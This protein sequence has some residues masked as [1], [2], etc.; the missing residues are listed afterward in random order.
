M[1]G[2]WTLPA[3]L[4]SDWR[5][6]APPLVVWLTSTPSLEIVKISPSMPWSKAKTVRALA[7]SIVRALARL[8]ASFLHPR[9]TE[10][11]QLMHGTTELNTGVPFAL[12]LDSR[13]A[14]T[15]CRIHG[16]VLL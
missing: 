5:W 13:P 1:T 14:S 12:M 11:A 10:L 16:C 15:V 6:A 3:T 2:A 9:T 4:A 8:L 7:S